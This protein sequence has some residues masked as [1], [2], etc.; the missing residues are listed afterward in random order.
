MMELFAAIVMCIVIFGGV[1]SY[2]FSRPA[3]NS[4]ELRK[5]RITRIRCEEEMEEAWRKIQLGLDD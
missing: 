3:P 2:L 1:L 5:K 4:L